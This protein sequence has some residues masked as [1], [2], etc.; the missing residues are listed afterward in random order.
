MR[1][2][3]AIF[4]VSFLGANTID[5]LKHYIAQYEY[6]NKNYKEALAKL[7]ELKPTNQ[8]LF[9]IA[10]TLYRLKRYNEAISYY[11]MVNSASLQG[12]VYFNIANCYYKLKKFNKATL[13]Y[14]SASKFKKLK[15]KALKNLKLSQ[16]K[17]QIARA[18]KIKDC[19]GKDVGLGKDR[20]KLFE[21][22]DP[23]VSKELKLANLNRVDKANVVVSNNKRV[24][25]I[26]LLKDK[27]STKSSKL[28][29]LDKLK[30]KRVNR[31]LEN[32]ELKTLLI[33]LTKDSNE[34]GN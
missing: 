6:K 26:E 16:K 2:L 8:V 24:S 3:L 30:E 14:K 18:S 28:F 19:K 5:N 17:A 4:I 1:A 31:A 15:Q 12:E 32:K 21:F 29:T 10:N 23:F 22:N 33:P 20:A 34:T 27:N 7:K 13:F 25:K 11:K 9:E